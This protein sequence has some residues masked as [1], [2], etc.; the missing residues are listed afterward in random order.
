MNVNGISSEGIS[1][2]GS[3]FNFSWLSIEFQCE[4]ASL[5]L[6]RG[7]DPNTSQVFQTPLQLAVSGGRIN[8][9]GIEMLLNV[10]ANVNAI[11]DDDAVLRK[12][13][14]WYGGDNEYLTAKRRITIHH[15]I[16]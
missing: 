4:A 8:I 1:V 7:A 10:N 15:F 9:P 13:R 5:L 3:I 12:L 2:L 16:L 14:R 11:A 6:R